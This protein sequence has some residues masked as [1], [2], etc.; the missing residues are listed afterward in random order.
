MSLLLQNL[1]ERTKF[2]EPQSGANLILFPLFVEPGMDGATP[3][4]LLDEA[5]RA[6][7]LEVSEV[8]ETGSVDRVLVFNRAEQP[9]LILDGEEILGA[10][11]NRM[12][13]A[14]IL[15]AA[16]TKVKVPVSCV[17]RGRW[18]CRSPLF[19]RSGEFGYSV[20]RKE[21][22]RQVAFNLE[23]S[24]EFITD[25]GAIWAEIDRKQER[26]KSRS[27]TDALHQIYRDYTEELQ[28]L[29][30]GFKIQNGQNG[31]AVFINNRF[32]C[33]DLFD[34]PETLSRLWEK[35]LRSYAMDALEARE[36]KATAGDPDPQAVL[37]AIAGSKCN[38]YSS[39]GLGSDLRL[40]GSGIV[41]AGLAL[42]Q[43]LLHFSV[44]ADEVDRTPQGKMNRPSARRRNLG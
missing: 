13:N 21:K 4:L 42:G 3:Y 44:F 23:Q 36:E 15:I 26:M 17:E 27:K 24:Q 22:A 8:S 1:L 40:A 5:F 16:N 39:V 32:V 7:C 20:L 25:Q 31:V 18:S 2:G 9:V 29:I 35:L 38:T 28:S 11:Q 10:K 12:V 34:R 14:T 33:L 43:A 37:D 6:E 19:E 30:S 41:G